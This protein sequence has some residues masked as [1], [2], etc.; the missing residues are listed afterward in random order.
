MLPVLLG[1]KYSLLRKCSF[2]L[3]LKDLV[4]EGSEE[5]PILHLRLTEPY[6]TIEEDEDKLKEVVA[7]VSCVYLQL[8]HFSKVCKL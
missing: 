8:L 4:R 1:L 6:E 5:S 3:R 7:I 2:C